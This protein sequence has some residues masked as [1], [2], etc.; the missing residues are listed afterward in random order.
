[1]IQTL[2]RANLLSSL[3]FIAFSTYL[4]IEL[5]LFSLLPF[6]FCKLYDLCELIFISFFTL[7]GFDR[8]YFNWILMNFHSSALL[9]ILVGV[10]FLISFFKY[11]FLS[12]ESLPSV[13]MIVLLLLS[14]NL[15]RRLN[16]LRYWELWLDELIRFYCLW[17]SFKSTIFNFFKW[18]YSYI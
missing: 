5:V 17:N 9:D 7:L 8:S 3:A 4:C 16:F 18:L 14:L 12:D 1:M 11:G 10:G 13:L 2:V 15:N 6:S